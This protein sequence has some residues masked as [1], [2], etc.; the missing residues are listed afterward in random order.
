MGTSTSKRSGTRRNRAAGAALGVLTLLL[1][2]CGDDD[3]ATTAPDAGAAGS[4]TV[5]VADG[6]DIGEILVDSD[7]NTLYIADGESGENIMCVEACLDAWPPLTVPSGEEPTASG[8][9]DGTLA[10]VE[11]EDGAVQVTYDGLPLYTFA[12]DSGPGDVSGHGISDELTWHA[13]TPDGPAELDD[14]DDSGGGYGG[15]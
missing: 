15:G 4:D 7:G 9:V 3:G 5:N 6:G 2:A 14:G 1:A 12:S 11:R 13:V 8:G 10:T